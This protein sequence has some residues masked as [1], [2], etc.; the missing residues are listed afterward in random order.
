VASGFS[1]DIAD[2]VR[3]NWLTE[4]DTEE[5]ELE[6]ELA[7]VLEPVEELL[8]QAAAARTSDPDATT[9]PILAIAIK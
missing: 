7:G 9:T 6:L 2:R 1:A 3:S 4:I 5:L 8:L